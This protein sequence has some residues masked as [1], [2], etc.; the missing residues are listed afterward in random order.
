MP[1]I[2]N[3]TRVIRIVTE[4]PQGPAGPPGAAGASYDHVQQTPASTWTVTHNLGHRPT[5]S[6]VVDE[7]IV[8]ADV[9]H[10]STNVLAIEFATAQS[11]FATLV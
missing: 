8:Y 5:V 6:V 7:E 2:L 3:T 4:G 1:T 9:T 10:I 11:G